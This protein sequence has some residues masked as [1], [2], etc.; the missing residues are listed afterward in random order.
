MKV[1]VQTVKNAEV[2]IDGVEKNSIGK[3]LLLLVGFTDGDD[4][5][6]I[7]KMVN[8]LS[9]LRIFCDTEGKINLSVRD[10]G[11]EVMIISNFTLYATIQKGFRPSFENALESSKSVVFY[12]IFVKKMKDIFQDRVQT[13][14]FGADMEVTSTN[15]GPKTFVYEIVNK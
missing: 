13:G 4:E 14:K 1:I 12:D 8:K 15:M 11:G 6:I 10:I 2:L 9:G 5:K 7:D 3:G